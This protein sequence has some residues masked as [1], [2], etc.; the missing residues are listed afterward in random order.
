ML[1]AFCTLI[2]YSVLNFV[3][4]NTYYSNMF[5]NHDCLEISVIQTDF[6]KSYSILLSNIMSITTANKLN[7][8]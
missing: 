6:E 3:I 1:L 8:V 2:L 7:L 5:D 4:W